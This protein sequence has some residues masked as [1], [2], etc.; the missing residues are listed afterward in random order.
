MTDDV[1]LNHFQ[2]LRKEHVDICVGATSLQF[3]NLMITYTQ[4]V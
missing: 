1:I 3:T 4:E 2:S